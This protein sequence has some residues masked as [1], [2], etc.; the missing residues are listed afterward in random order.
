VFG[1]NSDKSYLLRNAFTATAQD[2]GITIDEIPIMTN[3]KQILN[4]KQFFYYLE[5]PEDDRVVKYLSIIKG[6]FP[7]NFG[8]FHKL[9]NFF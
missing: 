2:Q 5:L 9:T 8:R 4:K 3:L 7:L 6:N 1:L